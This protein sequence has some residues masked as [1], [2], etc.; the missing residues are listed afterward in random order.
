MPRL[1]RSARLVAL[2]AV[3]LAARE[4]A[5]TVYEIGPDLPLDQIADAPWATLGP[6]DEVSIHWRAEPYREK[7]VIGRAGTAQAPI[8]VRGV[9][10]PGGERPVISGDGATTP[11]PLDFTG[12]RR[13]VLKIGT[14]NVPADT[15]PEYLVIEGLELRSAHPAYSF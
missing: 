8:V 13:G 2:L 7:W 4:A 15:L 3:G 1:D 9:R 6:G 5:A 11:E 12:E 10:G 14:S